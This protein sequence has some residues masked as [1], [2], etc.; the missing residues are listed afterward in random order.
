M[1]DTAIIAILLLTAVM[2][3][4]WNTAL[5][6]GAD[7]VLDMA[8]IRLFG[9]VFALVVIPL[10]PLPAAPAWPLL[11]ASAVAHLVYFS[12][13]IASYDRGDL[14][15]VYPIARGSAPLLVALAAYLVIGETPTPL[16]MAGVMTV[17]VGVIL[18]G[19]GAFRE[20]IHAIGFA[21]LTGLS[22]AS[23]SLLGGLGVRQ[24]GTV[25]GYAAWLELLTCVPF[26]AFAVI[27]RRPHVV[28]Y[29]ASP[30]ARRGFILGMG[31]VISYLVVLWAMTQ[32][33]IATV[34]AARETSAIFAAMAGTM[35]LKE[36]FAGRRIAAAVLVT[37]GIC[38]LVLG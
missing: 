1:S 6:T 8:A 32:L 30:A 35:L 12:C 17:S 5:K 4:T 38:L 37:L 34:T 14:S 13:L 10:A 16:G 22:I 20:N 24:S 9:I 21:L 26:I 3:A 11:I 18:A 25:L 29:I 36:P 19:T 31:S 28:A 33:P 15:Q 27:R 23:Y 7:R 2:H